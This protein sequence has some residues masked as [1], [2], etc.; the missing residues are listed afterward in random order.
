MKNITRVLTTLCLALLLCG[1]DYE[2]TPTAE[3][4]SIAYLRQHYTYYSIPITQPWYIT[5]RVTSCDREGNFYKTIVVEDATNSIEINVNDRQLHLTTPW[6]S[7]IELYIEGMWLG[8]YGRSFVIGAEPTGTFPVDDLDAR[9]FAHRLRVVNT[10]DT[11]YRPTPRKIG[12]LTRKDNQRWVIF[13][14]VQFTSDEIDQSWG[15]DTAT[16]F[17]H[18]I[19]PTGE[20]LRVATSA[21][22]M[23]RNAKLPE[24]SGSIDGIL[25]YRSGNY[26][27]WPTAIVRANMNLPRFEVR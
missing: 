22:A 24:G 25:Y 11:L 13:D 18:V 27:L 21:Y 23:W 1:C 4:I 17:R 19:C 3:H 8:A 5:G 10:S 7:T 12:Q 14:S 20:T 26:E 2:S 16:T 15:C 6:C 9:D